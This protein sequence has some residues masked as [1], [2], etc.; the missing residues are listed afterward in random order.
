MS[1]PVEA[2]ANALFVCYAEDPAPLQAH[3]KELYALFVARP[4]ADVGAPTQAAGARPLDDT[5]YK[6]YALSPADLDL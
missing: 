1:V 2:G 6:A 3:S 4:H 5:A